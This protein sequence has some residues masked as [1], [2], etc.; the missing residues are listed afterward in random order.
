MSQTKVLIVDD[1][2]EFASALAER[3]QLRGYDAKAVYHSDDAFAIAKSY[4]P[5]MILLDLK[6]PGKGGIEILMTIKEFAPDIEVI[7][8]TGHM[9]L[10]CKIEGIKI[11]AF[12]CITK[13]VDIREL[14][15]KIENASRKINPDKAGGR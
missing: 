1:E 2:I 5:D 8:L 9:D 10:E 4:L 3:L 6:M 7:L 12:D 14:I 11:G 15:T 13:P